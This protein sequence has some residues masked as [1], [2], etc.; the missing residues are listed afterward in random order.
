MPLILLLG[1]LPFGRQALAQ[2]EPVD[3]NTPGLFLAPTVLLGQAKDNSDSSAALATGAGL[4]V[5]YI[6]KRDTWNRIELSVGIEW[7]KARL[8][9]LGDRGTDISVVTEPAAFLKAGYGYSLGSHAFGIW[10]LGIG[11]GKAAYEGVFQEDSFSA[12]SDAF[13]AQLGWDAVFPIS[14]NLSLNGGLLIRHVSADFGSLEQ[15]AARLKIGSVDYSVWAAQLA[16]RW[17]L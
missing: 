14:T 16:V 2:T 10:R 6:L 3:R 8:G 11:F 13:L 5:G 1:V 15:K 12:E 4:D 7:M 9:D 17:Q